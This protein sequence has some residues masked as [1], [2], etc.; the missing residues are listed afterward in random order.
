MTL[1]SPQLH[2]IT[3]LE[4]GAATGHIKQMVCETG[5]PKDRGNWGLV[6]HGYP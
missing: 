1:M 6:F 2:L 5:S 4:S 3:L